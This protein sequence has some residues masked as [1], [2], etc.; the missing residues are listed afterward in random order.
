[1][2]KQGFGGC[3]P[4]RVVSTADSGTPRAGLGQSIRSSCSCSFRLSLHFLRLCGS[5]FCHF[6]ILEAL[7]APDHFRRQNESK[8][9]PAQRL[10]RSDVLAVVFS[11]LSLFQCHKSSVL[12]AYKYQTQTKTTRFGVF[13]FCRDSRRNKGT[14]PLPVG[15]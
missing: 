5:V 6:L 14:P 15:S 3:P 11:A 8:I 12:S 4:F 9:L 13:I 2:Y 1:M 10:F 7:N